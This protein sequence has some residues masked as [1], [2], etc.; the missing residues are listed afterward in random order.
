MAKKKSAYTRF[1]GHRKTPHLLWA[2][3]VGLSL[4][5]LA[6]EL[7]FDRHSHFA[8]HGL[9]SIDGVF[10]FN[11]ALGAFSCIVLILLA[12]VLGYFFKVDVTYY[13]DVD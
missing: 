4:F 2:L 12:K 7:L 8:H 6:I 9:M 10:G 5:F 1:F 13:D 11:S 3:L